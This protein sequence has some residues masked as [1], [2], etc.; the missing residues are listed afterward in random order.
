[1]AK[2]F[3]RRAKR[4]NVLSQL[5]TPPRIVNRRAW[6]THLRPNRRETIG[7][8]AKVGTLN[9][10]RHCG[11]WGG[12]GVAAGGGAVARSAAGVVGGAASFKG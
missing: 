2:S 1:M 7:K 4:T 11:F 9:H 5:T 8:G 6:A 10:R 12:T 3:Q